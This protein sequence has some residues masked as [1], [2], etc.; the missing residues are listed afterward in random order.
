MHQSVY[1]KSP[2]GILQITCTGN[3]VSQVSF[4]NRKGAE[5]IQEDEVVIEEPGSPALKKCIDQLD[6][7]FSGRLFE[8]DLELEQPGTDFQQTVWTELL[9][10]GYGRTES[11]LSLSKR[12]GNVKAIRAV[13]TANGKNNIAII[14]PCHRVIGSNGSLVGYGGDLWRKQWLLQHEAKYANGVQTLF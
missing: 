4:V 12:I 6:N 11:Y 1:Y 2:L 8:F 10:I 3:A 13:G 7:Y 5:K 9:K 14:V